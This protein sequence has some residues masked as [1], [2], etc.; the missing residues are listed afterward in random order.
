MPR[1]RQL[2]RDCLSAAQQFGRGDIASLEGHS[3]DDGGARALSP[4]GART[5]RSRLSTPQ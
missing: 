5:A 2:F 4:S 3:N 1:L